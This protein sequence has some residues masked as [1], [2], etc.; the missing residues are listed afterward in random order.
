MKI[1]VFYSLEEYQLREFNIMSVEELSEAILLLLRDGIKF[2][3]Y[4]PEED[5]DEYPLV[6]GLSEYVS[7]NHASAVE[8]GLLEFYDE[9]NIPLLLQI[10]HIFDGP[11]RVE[12]GSP[13]VFER[14]EL[15]KHKD[16]LREYLQTTPLAEIEYL[17]ER[18]IN[19]FADLFLISHLSGGKI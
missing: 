3:W 2:N 19:T 16:A 12:Y 1:P 15:Q 10:Y 9:D 8:H 17:P 13:I 6:L 11:K 4:L 14:K 7:V 5:E 18:G